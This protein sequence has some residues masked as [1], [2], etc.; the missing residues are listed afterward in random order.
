VEI[1]E[2]VREG[3]KK[4][5]LKVWIH[6]IP[7]ILA[8]IDIKDR[9]IRK[10]ITDLLEKISQK[11]PQALLYSLSVLQKSN[12]AERR[13]AA[14]QIIEKLKGSQQILIEQA[15]MIANELIRS[16]ILLSEIWNEAIEEASRIYF[17]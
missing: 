10:S 2:I 15:S 1:E 11:F 9:V 4:I 8:R 14:S 17:G 6:V 3:F 7:Q 13:N 12:S 16:A 5:D